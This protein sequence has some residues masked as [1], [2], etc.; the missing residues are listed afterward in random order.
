MKNSKI[1]RIISLIALI[2]IITSTLFSLKLSV[3]AEELV[4]VTKTMIETSEE[5]TTVFD[6]VTDNPISDPGD[7]EEE[8]GDEH[9]HQFTEE[10]IDAGSCTSDRVVRQICD[11]GFF[12][13]EVIP[14]TGHDFELVS[15]VKNGNI[16]VKTYKCNVCGKI[17]SENISDIVARVY[18]CAKS[19]FSL[20]GHTW[21]YVENLSD[22][23]LQVGLYDLPPGEGVSIGSFGVTRS[24]GAGLYY[25]VESYC[26]NKYGLRRTI[27]MSEDINQE[28]LDK[29]NKKILR[30]N[31]WDPITNCT[32]FSFGVWN[33]VSKRKLIPLLLPILGRFE[34]VLHKH[35]SNPEM[36]YPLSNRVYKQ[37]KNRDKAYLIPVSYDSISHGI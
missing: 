14:S 27:Y 23:N 2:G 7:P 3:S 30:S 21:I 11:C 10:V 22:H 9:V 33:S 15:E 34:M 13:D 5:T 4:V 35:D 16:I 8:D 18:I 25:N 36:F 19:S 20:L 32:G 1:M 24:D 31:H 17:Y 28:K 26:V 37:K 12:Y 29:A 6:D